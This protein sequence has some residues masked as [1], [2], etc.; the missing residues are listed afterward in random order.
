M[1]KT[2]IKKL[3]SIAVVF[4]FSVCLCLGLLFYFRTPVLTAFLGKEKVPVVVVSGTWEDMGFQIGSRNEFAAG[5]RRTAWLARRLFPPERARSYFKRVESFIPRSSLDHMRGIAKGVAAVS[6]ISYDDAWEDILLLNF[7]YMPAGCT[8]FAVCSQAGSYIAHNTDEYYV[9]TFS[10]AVIV[11][12]PDNESGY[13]FVSFG[14]PAFGGVMMGE[15]TEGLAAVCNAAFPSDRVLGLPPQFLVRRSLEECSS[16][17]D[18]VRLFTSFVEKGGRFGYI[19]YNI[20]Y[21]D[22]TAGKLA[23]LEI[24]P[25]RVEVDYGQAWG[26]KRFVAAA[27][28][29]SLMPGR[30]Q[31]A[32]H[33]TSSYA[34]YERVKLLLK[35]E[36]SYNTETIVRILA[37]HD[38]QRHGTNHTI[39]RHTNLNKGTCN[40][41]FFDS[42]FTLY[43]MLGN[44]CRYSEN[45][46][47]LQ[48][49]R[50]TDMLGR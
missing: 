19:G 15:N 18:A 16:I 31:R 41:L 27:N 47:A 43:Y 29:Y 25:D 34:R 26:E 22:F 48:T 10:Q 33:N 1:K 38:E 8:A 49:I 9:L 40:C 21:I 6:D 4:F 36:K 39:C 13:P 3:Y 12:N 14:S 30:N 32:E 37:D 17:E 46:Q 11:F 42:T 7:A 28:H 20:T 44:P 5:I 50:W 45:P 24:A 35:R 2:R 23:R